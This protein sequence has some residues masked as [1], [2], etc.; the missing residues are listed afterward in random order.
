M[1]IEEHAQFSILNSDTLVDTLKDYKALILAEQ[2]ILN[3]R[4]CD[5]IRRFVRDGGALVATGFAI[6]TISRL[7]ISRWRTC[8]EYDTCEA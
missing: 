2:S 8:S 4:E 1:L 7:V 3:P 5:A 6:R